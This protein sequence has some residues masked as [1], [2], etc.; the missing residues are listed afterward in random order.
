MIRQNSIYFEL[1]R[2]VAMLNQTSNIKLTFLFG[3]KLSKT[4]FDG[5]LQNP[6][7]LLYLG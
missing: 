6:K 2:V 7:Q 5:I 1:H 4:I 3:Q